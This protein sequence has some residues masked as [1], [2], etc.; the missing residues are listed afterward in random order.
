MRLC[1]KSRSVLL[2]LTNNTCMYESIN[3][4]SKEMLESMVHPTEEMRHKLQALVKRAKQAWTLQYIFG[5][6]YIHFVDN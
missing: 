2:V 3:S 1:Y 4:E 6:Q 5:G